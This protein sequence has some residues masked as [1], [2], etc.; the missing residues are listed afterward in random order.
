MCLVRF[1]GSPQFPFVAPAGVMRTAQAASANLPPS[2]S[3]RVKE[4]KR[5]GWTEPDLATQRKHAPGKL[6]LAA[7]LRRETILPLK[8]IVWRVQLGT[9]KSANGRLYA[10]MKGQAQRGGDAVMVSVEEKE[11]YA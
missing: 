9:S 3:R 1:V 4:L 10:W 8:W 7:R 11:V 5:L 2:R 6:N